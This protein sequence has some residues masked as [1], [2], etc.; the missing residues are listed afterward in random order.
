[1]L[2]LINLVIIFGF[3]ALKE[4]SQMSDSSPGQ[5]CDSST[6]ETFHSLSGFNSSL[7]EHVRVWLEAIVC[8]RH[9]VDSSGAARFHCARYRMSSWF[10]P[11]IDGKIPW[12]RTGHPKTSGRKLDSWC[13]LKK[14]KMFD[15][16]GTTIFF[17]FLKNNLYG[18]SFLRDLS[19]TLL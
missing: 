1:M 10:I 6:H 9:V 17:I 13:Q 8:N 11:V 5:R 2:Y 15:S 3:S 7:A 16:I 4:R 19:M 12:D 18:G 14:K